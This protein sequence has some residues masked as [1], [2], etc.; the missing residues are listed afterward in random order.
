VTVADVRPYRFPKTIF[1]DL[2]GKLISALRTARRD[3]GLTQVQAAEKLGCRQ[4]FLSKIECGERRMDV[5]EF[6]VMC[7]AYG[8]APGQLLDSLAASVR[9]KSRSTGRK[10]MR[11]G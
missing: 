1:S 6:V 4:T 10:K 8:V 9:A 11:A 7:D 2:S 5:I 3:A